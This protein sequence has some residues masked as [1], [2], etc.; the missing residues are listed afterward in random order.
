MPFVKRDADGKIAALILQATEE[1]REEVPFDDSELGVF[2]QNSLI[3]AVAQ[4]HWVET[5]H[6]LA[7]V[8]EDLIDLLIEKNVFRFY[9]LPEAAQEKLIQRRGLRREF[10]Y[11]ETLFGD[12]EDDDF[13]ETADGEDEGY[14]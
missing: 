1:G 14:L 9:D 2:L 4:R 6:G 8:M 12:T 13:V 3:D 10:A 5:D 7:R 11:V